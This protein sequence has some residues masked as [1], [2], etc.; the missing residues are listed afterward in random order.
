M[1]LSGLLVIF[2]TLETL[3]YDIRHHISAD[4]VPRSPS[5][6]RTR[7]TVLSSLQV[8]PCR[9]KH[10]LGGELGTD[11][12]GS[13]CVL[14]LG[15]LARL[16]AKVCLLELPPRIHVEETGVQTELFISSED[17]HKVKMAAAL[18]GRRCTDAHKQK[19]DD[20]W[21]YCVVQL[22][23]FSFYFPPLLDL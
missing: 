7:S 1:S 8:I 3:S 21:V 12:D 5:P 16:G 19:H 22:L 11:Q 10:V 20:G 9:R 23:L 15:S 6:S 13:G 17:I 14:L 4:T 2:Y 18:L